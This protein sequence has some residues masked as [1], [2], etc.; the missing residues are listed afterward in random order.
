M[1][2]TK[3][4]H[5]FYYK[6][7]TSKSRSSPLSFVF[8]SGVDMLLP[9]LDGTVRVCMVEIQRIFIHQFSTH[10]G[11]IFTVWR[12]CSRARVVGDK[13]SSQRSAMATWTWKHQPVAVWRMTLRAKA[14]LW[15]STG[16][17]P[18]TQG[19]SD[20]P[21][22]QKHLYCGFAGVHCAWEPENKVFRLQ[23]GWLGFSQRCHDGNAGEGTG[24]EGRSLV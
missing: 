16:G 22:N 1:F 8:S 5:D 13:M 17:A 14:E 2:L 6:L 7:M 19:R 9:L 11:Q 12:Q 23:C 15:R 4:T 24:L 10:I 20:G 18:L 3:H 21:A